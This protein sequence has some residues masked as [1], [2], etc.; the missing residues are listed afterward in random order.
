MSD[1]DFLAYHGP[2]RAVL[3]LLPYKMARQTRPLG[4][5]K[6]RATLSQPLFCSIKSDSEDDEDYIPPVQEESKD[7]EAEKRARSDL[8]AIFQASVASTSKMSHPPKKMVKI[9]KTFIFAETPLQRSPEA[10]VNKTHDDRTRTV[11]FIHV[12][13]TRS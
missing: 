6:S 8:W 4:R 9:K 3:S 10:F 7:P 1:I 12:Q 11:Q 13:T 2:E 5:K